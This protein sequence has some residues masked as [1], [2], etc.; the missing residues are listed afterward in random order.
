MEKEA[1]C[2]SNV[3]KEEV[4]KEMHGRISTRSI[5]VR[6]PSIQDMFLIALAYVW[7]VVVVLN[8]NSV[9]HAS[10][11]KNYHLLEIAVGMTGALLVCNILFGGLR[12]TG[13]SVLLA[14]VL[15]GYSS[16]YFAIQSSKMT[17]QNFFL[18]FLIGLPCLFL[19][20][21]GLHRQGKLLVLF[22]RLAN[23]VCVFAAM[24]LF[25][26]I[27]G[28]LLK[29]I[30]PNMY[31]GIRWGN[32]GRVDGYYGLHFQ[33]QWDTTFSTGLYRNSGI[34]TE[35]PMLNLWADIALAVELLLRPKS[36]KLRVLILCATIVTTMST[37]GLIFMALCLVLKNVR[38]YGRM[39]RWVK[40]LLVV[41]ALVVIPAIIY[42]LYQVL[43]L[44]SYTTSYDMRLS[45]YVGGLNMWMDYPVF[46]GGYGNLDV[47]LEYIY[48][49]TGVVGFSNSIL[50]VLATGGLWM[51]ILFYIPHVGCMFRKT[52][53]SRDLALFSI[54]YFYL[55]CTTAFFARYLAVV[56]VAFGLAVMHSRS[57]GSVPGDG[58]GR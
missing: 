50:A 26:W 6:L 40:G 13:R 51:A 12:L 43:V 42:L 55:F 37:T 33:I 4:K 36:S 7:C 29:L 21:E 17:M 30:E 58:A 49:P 24:S 1:Y 48:S 31:T 35:A 32:F 19:L 41:A 23:V 2:C 34:F 22:Y 45:D 18:L 27:F 10:F 53:G 46:G 16:V 14:V 15:L 57:N 28:E 39:N 5:M 8:G 52:T 25:F 44:K 38:D 3:S 11:S 20:F 54:C 47:L 56:M 9:Y